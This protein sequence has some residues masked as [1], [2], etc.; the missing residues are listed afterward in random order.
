[1]KN[2]LIESQ[3]IALVVVIFVVAVLLTLTGAG[4]LFSGLDLKVTSALKTGTVALQIADTGIQH[5]LAII[6]AGTSFSY[7]SPTEIVPSTPHP[8][9]PGYSYSVTAVN[10]AGNSQAIFTSTATGP[11]NTKKVIVAYIGRGSFGLGATS[12]PGS[13]AANTETNFSGTS[14][15]INGNDNCN[16]AP[17]VPGIV[18]TDPVLATEITNNTTS[19]GGLASNQM[20]LVT[21]SGGS[22]SVATIQ[23][24]SQT[25]SQIADSYLNLSVPGHTDLE[26]GN[27][28]S[29]DNWG[30]ST[31]PRITHITG[32][33]KIEGTIE[34]YG[35]LIADGALEVQGNFTFHG[36]VIV[37]GQVQVEVTGN[38]GIYG[39]L[40]IGESTTSDAGYELDV[41]GNAHVRFDSCALSPVDNWV[42]LPKAA[43]LLAWQ[44]KLTN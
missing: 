10:T 41:R 1:M 30:T 34:G 39:S 25:V 33:A 4:L 9:I 19:D 21:G 35:V 11:N 44:E 5:A 31:L 23:P 27:Y 22:P 29:N 40:M 36:L 8:T 2:K 3:G 15:T 42:P 24:L 17:A 13:T 14:F 26:G 12:L 28:S 38:A 7:S 20:N 37:R 43:K 6:P 18:V 32:D 16:A